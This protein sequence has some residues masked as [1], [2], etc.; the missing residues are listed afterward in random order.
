[1]LAKAT[2]AAP[3]SSLNSVS[4][5]PRERRQDDLGL[6]DQ[7]D[8]DVG[9]GQQRFDVLLRDVFE[10]LEDHGPRVERIGRAASFC[11]RRKM[12]ASRR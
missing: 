12:I 7:A 1:M 6:L 3:L 2:A 10:Q 5:T 8:A 9:P 4:P 11:L